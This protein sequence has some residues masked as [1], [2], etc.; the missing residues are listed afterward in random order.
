MLTFSEIK[1]IKKIVYEDWREV[2]NNIVNGDYDFEVGDYRFISHS[3]IDEILE[4]EL[5]NDPYLLGCFNASFLEEYTGWPVEL[6]EAAQ[7]SDKGTEALGEALI[8]EDKVT[9]IAEGYVFSDGYGHYFARYD[10]HENSLF[11]KNY[12]DFYVFKVD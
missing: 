6:I 9:A 8:K 4:E 12:D 2:V 5:K 3:S 7:E 11:L 1:A 10:G